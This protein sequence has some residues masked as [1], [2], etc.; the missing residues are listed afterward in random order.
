MDAFTSGDPLPGPA[1]HVAVPMVPRGAALDAPAIATA[2]AAQVRRTGTHAL[3]A[4]TSR[5]RSSSGYAPRQGSPPTG[6]P[7]C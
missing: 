5:F 6:S 1:T 4:P 7:R 2:V 3:P